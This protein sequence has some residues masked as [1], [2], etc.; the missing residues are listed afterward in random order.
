MDAILSR[1]A[2]RLGACGVDDAWDK[3]ETWEG[4]ERG[5]EGSGRAGNFDHDGLAGLAPAENSFSGNDLPTKHAMDVDPVITDSADASVAP[6]FNAHAPAVL[7][8]SKTSPKQGASIQ[9]ASSGG[10]ML[11]TVCTS[12]IDL[13]QGVTP[14]TM[15]SASAETPTPA[16]NP[17]IDPDPASNH[18][19]HCSTIC[20]TAP[21]PCPIRFFPCSTYPISGP[22]AMTK[23]EIANAMA[24]PLAVVVIGGVASVLGVIESAGALLTHL[25]SW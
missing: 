1:N 25:F 23:T 17:T 18:R 21:H 24:L 11:P 13:T 16:Y 10:S 12:I 2:A 19:T 7:P 14:S 4:P 3:Q 8:D 15:T 9:H 20:T 22:P 5:R 6:G